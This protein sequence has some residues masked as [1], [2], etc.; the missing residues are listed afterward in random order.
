VVD[1]CLDSEFCSQATGVLFEVLDADRKFLI[2]V[3]IE[4]FVLSDFG[5]PTPKR[6]RRFPEQTA[7]AVRAS[8]RCQSGGSD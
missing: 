5:L 2:D 4:T 3:S 7:C 8:L 6:R 1:E